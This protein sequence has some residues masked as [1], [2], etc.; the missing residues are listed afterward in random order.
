MKLLFRRGFAVAA[1]AGLLAFG[2]VACGNAG[3]DAGNSNN[4]SA[5]AA[6]DAPE[7]ETEPAPALGCVELGDQVWTLAPDPEMRLSEMPPADFNTLATWMI[8]NGPDFEDA[9]L[10][11]MVV[12]WGTFGSGYY[13]M[14]D[15][16]LSDEDATTFETA[17]EGIDAACDGLGFGFEEEL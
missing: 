13:E 16:A 1:G 4:D 14:G 6:A 8:D 11:V 15:E 2:L 12:E 3:D 5:A 17:S 10:G 9:D 7:T